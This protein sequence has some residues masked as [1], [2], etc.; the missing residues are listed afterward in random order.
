MV[1]GLL[2]TGPAPSSFNNDDEPFN[3]INVLTYFLVQLN[4]TNQ[5]YV[6]GFLQQVYETRIFKINYYSVTKFCHVKSG[7]LST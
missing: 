5:F 6:K 1:E 4:F 2:S 7:C 3:K